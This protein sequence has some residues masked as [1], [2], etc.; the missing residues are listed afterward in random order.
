MKK[1]L[2]TTVLVLSVIFTTGCAG[3]LGNKNF[4]NKF[5]E[6]FDKK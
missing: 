1:L 6:K 5:F 2:L 3:K 4:E